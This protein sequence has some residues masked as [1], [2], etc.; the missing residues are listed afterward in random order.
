MN[1]N[2]P[3]IVAIG[4]LGLP[5]SQLVVW[6]WNSW[7]APKHGLPIMDALAIGSLGT[8]FTAA[9]QWI[10]RQS[11]RNLAYVV[12]KYGNLEGEPN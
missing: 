5:A 1:E 9:F 7:L 12:N 6:L 2:R 8:F 4:V 10:D 3:N 11:K